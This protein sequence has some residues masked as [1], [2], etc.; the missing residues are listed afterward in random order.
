MIWSQPFVANIGIGQLD[1]VVTHGVIKENLDLHFG[2][3]DHRARPLFHGDSQHQVRFR[4]GIG[5]FRSSH[6]SNSKRRSRRNSLDAAANTRCV[7][8]A[9]RFS[10]VERRTAGRS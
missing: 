9:R 3:I 8:R 10:G 5:R 7:E 6:F 2:V 1:V 4:I